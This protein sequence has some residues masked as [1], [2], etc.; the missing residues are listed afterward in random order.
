[1]KYLKP[2]EY[3]EIKRVSVQAVR[4]WCRDGTIEAV[5]EGKK[6]WR[7]PFD[8]KELLHEKRPN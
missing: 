8:E 1:M 5:R 7:I 6:L 3:A 4:Q 2:S